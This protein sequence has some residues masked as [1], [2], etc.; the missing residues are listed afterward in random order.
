M[1]LPVY[2]IGHPV[3]R[4]QTTEI[5]MEHPGLAELIENM[6]ET[7][8]H[9]KGVG[10][11]APQIG[12]SIRLFV[13]DTE[14]FLESDPETEHLKSAFINPVI[15]DEFG[16]DFI[17][18]EGCLSIPDVHADVTRKSELTI[19]YTDESG[20][21]QTRDFKGLTARVIQHEYDH[22]EGNIF[23]DK[24]PPIKKMVLK[25]KLNDIATGKHRPFYKSII[26]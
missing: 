13:I 15:E 14:P 10:L 17:F 4:K 18:N 20:K 9:D 22:L 12:Q 6:Y 16:E 23:T 26:K 5:T 2:L 1:I 25:R 19:T 11:A 7:M 8:Y 24:I 3:L 21:R